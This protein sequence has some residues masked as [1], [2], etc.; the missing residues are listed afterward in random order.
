MIRFHYILAVT[1]TCV[2]LFSSLLQKR[3]EKL[4][5][6]AW[7]INNYYSYLPLVFIHHNPNI[8]VWN[9]DDDRKKN[10][11]ML[12]EGP[13]KMTIGMSFF[14]LPGFLIAHVSASAL[15]YEADGLSLPY[16]LGVH[17]SVYLWLLL[18]WIALLAVW[19]RMGVSSGESIAGALLLLLAT[20]LYYYTTDEPAFT[21]P[22]TFVLLS[23]LMLLSLKWWD[24]PKRKTLFAMAFITG[25][26]ALVRPV[27]VIFVFIPFII[28]F[29]N[30]SPKECISVIRV[31]WKPVLLAIPIGLIAVSPQF[32][33]WKAAFGEW[34]IYSYGDEGF[35]CSNPQIGNGLLSY[36]KGWLLYTPFAWVMLLGFIPLYRK[37]KSFSIALMVF[38]I[39]FL[40]IVFSW[41]C[42]WYGGSF[43]QRVM[44]D[45][46]PILSIPMMTMIAAFVRTQRKWITVV[47]GI[48]GLAFILQSFVFLNQYRKRYIHWGA[49]SKC[50]FHQLFKGSLPRA[51]WEALFYHADIEKA[52][53]GKEH[54]PPKGG[55]DSFCSEAKSDLI[56]ETR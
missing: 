7:D 40:Y 3:W 24:N 17:F 32:I 20:N 15:G 31:Q 55:W 19:K 54:Y 5:V 12:L 36:R 18:G 51:E 4:P 41:W 45:I 43:S 49:N 44:V 13:E 10:G 48:L 35:F 22:I 11:Y 37:N 52:M 56:N 42:W 33:Y 30:R 8:K 14:Y 38:L 46:Y 23:V 53:I 39:V 2:S 16:Q 21:H 29:L 26:I 25:I 1:L 34:F 9:D 50:S 27:N 6:I 47:G 28:G